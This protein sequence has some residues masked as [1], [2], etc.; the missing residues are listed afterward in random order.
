[1]NKVA[2]IAMFLWVAGWTIAAIRALL[3]TSPVTD[4]N[5]CRTEFRTGLRFTN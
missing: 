5:R 4:D 1:M 2:M 3:K